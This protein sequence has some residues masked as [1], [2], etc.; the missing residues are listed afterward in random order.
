MCICMHIIIHHSLNVKTFHFFK[1]DFF[2]KNMAASVKQPV[3]KS[4]RSSLH[5]NIIDK[6]KKKIE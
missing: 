2:L 1:L 5:F 3:S 6:K 4:L